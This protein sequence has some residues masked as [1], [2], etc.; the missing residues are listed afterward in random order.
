M[1]INDRMDEGSLI[2]QEKLTVAASYTTPVLTE[3]LIE[4]SNEMLRKYIPSYLSG[5]TKPFTQSQ[6]EISYSRKL[7]KADSLIDWS[8]TADVLEKEIRAFVGWPKSVATLLNKR[9]IITEARV[10]NNKD[11]GAL[12]VPCH[13]SYLEILSLI[14]PSGKRMTGADFK[15]GYDER[16]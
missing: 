6:E 15:R 2:A 5:N 7:T 14:G 10:A 8:K 13:N 11:D 16:E 3:K 9:V 12:V 4:L 1:I